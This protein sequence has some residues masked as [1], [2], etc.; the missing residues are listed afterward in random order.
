MVKLEGS[1]YLMR[2][3]LVTR[4]LDENDRL[5]QENRKEITFRPMTA[6]LIEKAPAV[7]LPKEGRYS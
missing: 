4:L 6:E 7:T 3:P 5:L 1:P 2:A